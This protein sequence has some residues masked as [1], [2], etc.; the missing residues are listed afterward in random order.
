M[1][2]P[3][4]D[5]GNPQAPPPG[6]YGDPYG[7]QGGHQY[8]QPYG[9]EYPQPYGYAPMAFPPEHPRATTVLVLGI[10]GLV[11]CGIVSPFA[12]V[13][14]KRTLA[15]IDDSNG[16]LGGRGSAQA[17]YVMGIVGSVLLGLAV[18][19]VVAVVVL[20]ILLVGGTMVSVTSNA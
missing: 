20:V 17:G 6:Q 18:L 15:E 10:L 4:E 1:T 5:D 13:M 2:N 9:P 7:Q 3:P 11:A 8:G 14:G 12:W 19:T 16:Q